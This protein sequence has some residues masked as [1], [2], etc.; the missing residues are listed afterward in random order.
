MRIL[1]LISSNGL[2]GAERV[3]IELSKSLKRMYKCAPIV[4]VIKNM[5]NPHTEIADEAEACDIESVIFDCNGQFDAKPVS[6]IKKFIKINHIDIAHCHGYK[7]NIYGLLAAKNKIPTITT[8]H[9]W[10]K[11]HWKLKVYCFLDGLWIRYFD[12]IVAVSD[13]VRDEMIGYKIPK[14]KIE[15]IDNGIDLSRFD[16]DVIFS[17]N[18]RGELG[19]KENDKVIGT[20]GSLGYEKGHVY[21]LRTAK[22]I[23]RAN[24]RVK[25]LIVG[26]GPL[27][28]ELEDETERL[29]IKNDVIFAGYRRDITELLSVFDIFALP[30]IIEG[31]PMVILEAMAS[32]K[33]VVASSVGAIP[34]V[35]KN[36]E[37]GLL[38]EPGNVDQ[39]K[40]TINVLLR[41]ERKSSQIALRGYHTVEREYSSKRMSIN[42]MNL[43][44][45][46]LTQIA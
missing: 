23:L 19:I 3:V 17:E 35:I 45:G 32:K 16:K 42:Y 18:I 34:N 6:S 27:R 11:S 24:K 31:L 4:G 2:F 30:S 22:E 28:K 40:H 1:H 15:V 29:D 12:R 14:D 26:D 8:N 43:Y 33:P 39:L 21:L 20:I 36:G 37:N 41:D 25:F 7:S 38:C 5:H 9:N 46:L 10:L 13:L 44:N